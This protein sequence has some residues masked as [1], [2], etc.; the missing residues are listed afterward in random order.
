[1]IL[2]QSIQEFAR[3]IGE[4]PDDVN[5][6]YVAMLR[7]A[8]AVL[9]SVLEIEVR[10][11]QGQSWDPLQDAPL[12]EWMRRHGPIEIALAGDLPE[13]H[14]WTHPSQI[15]YAFLHRLLEQREINKLLP[16]VPKIIST[17]RPLH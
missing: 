9:P 13:T 5:S 15:R 1:M 12:G 10:G 6:A 4:E 16:L 17:G 8:L 3:S 11:K 14:K 2:I 7:Q